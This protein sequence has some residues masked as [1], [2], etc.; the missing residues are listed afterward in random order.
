[1]ASITTTAAEPYLGLEGEAPPAPRGEEA[2]NALTHGIGLLLSAAAAYW[3]AATVVPS[4]DLTR[5]VGCCV[6]A[7]SLVGVYLFSTLS[8]SFACPVRRGRFRALDQAFI[9]LLIVGTYT[10]VALTFL[11]SGMHTVLLA[12]MWGVAGF[13]FLSKTVWRHRIDSISTFSYLA[14]AWLPVVS[15]PSAWLL[16]PKPA[17]LL[18]VAGGLCYTVGVVFL[19]CDRRVR[20]FHAVWHLFVMAG[21]ALHYAAILRHV[22]NP[23]VA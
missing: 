15:I 10:P 23:V 4:S 7:A 19:L 21:S 13:G 2:V 20:Y 14:L 11:H 3:L 22:A 1:M 9:Y 6:Y 12:V 17:L 5:I 18:F 8:H 16:M